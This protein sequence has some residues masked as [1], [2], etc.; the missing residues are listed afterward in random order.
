METE[1][2]ILGSEEVLTLPVV[3]STKVIELKEYLAA[4]LGGNRSMGSEGDRSRYA[5]GSS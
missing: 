5:V 3:T 4:R 1:L 2:R